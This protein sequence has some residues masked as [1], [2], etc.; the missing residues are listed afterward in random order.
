MS[1]NVYGCR[2]THKKSS[3]KM[4]KIIIERLGGTGEHIDMQIN[5]RERKVET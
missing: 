2:V 5:G 1:A 3:I 4:K